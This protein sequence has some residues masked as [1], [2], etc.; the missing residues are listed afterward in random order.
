M[1]GTMVLTQQRPGILRLIRR[2]SPSKPSGETYDEAACQI[3]KNIITDVPVVEILTADR[4]PLVDSFILQKINEDESLRNSIKESITDNDGV[5]TLKSLIDASSND[6]VITLWRSFTRSDVFLDSIWDLAHLL[7]IFAPV[8]G[9]EPKT[10]GEFHTALGHILQNRL[11]ELDEEKRMAIFPEKLINNDEAIAE[12]SAN[13]NL[14]REFSSLETEEVKRQLRNL[15]S[16]PAFNQYIL[17]GTGTL[18]LAATTGYMALHQQDLIQLLSH[19]TSFSNSVPPSAPASSLPDG[20]TDPE[21][22]FGLANTLVRLL[23]KR[24]I[25]AVTPGK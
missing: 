18:A 17:Q 8:E 11:G 20:V 5:T 10:V 6:E 21:S 22:V 7:L 16:G 4:Q 12:N 15:V 13:S 2:N 24:M 19:F 25:S 23:L 3:Q 1:E 9:L 14:R